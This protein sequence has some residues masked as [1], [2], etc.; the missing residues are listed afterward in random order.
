VALGV[1]LN[2]GLE[3]WGCGFWDDDFPNVLPEPA[4]ELQ[5]RDNFLACFRQASQKLAD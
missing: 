3:L 4:L 2:P 1:L 5:G